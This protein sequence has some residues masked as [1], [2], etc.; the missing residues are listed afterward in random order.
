MVLELS[1][2]HQGLTTAEFSARISAATQEPLAV[3]G[4]GGSG[5]VH[6]AVESCRRLRRQVLYVVADVDTALSAAADAGFYGERLAPDEPATSRNAA[7]RNTTPRTAKRQSAPVDAVEPGTVE[8]GTV[9]PG[10][11]EPGTVEPGTRGKRTPSSASSLASPVLV[12]PSEDPPWAQVHPDRRATMR[13]LA[14]LGRLVEEPTPRVVIVSAGALKRRVPSPADLRRQCLTLRVGDTVRLDELVQRLSLAGYLRVPLAEDPGTM[15]LRGGLLDLWS[16]A[17]ESPCRI[18]LNGEVVERL[19]SFDPENQRTQEDFDAY[20]V[21]PCVEGALDAE[22]RKQ[23]TRRVSALADAIDYP[24]NQTKRLVESL[25]AGQ[26]FF[27]SASYAVALGDWGSLLDYFPADVPVLVED[28]AKV[29]AALREEDDELRKSV[30]SV[31]DRPHFPFEAW[32]FDDEALDDRL[33]LH[34]RVSLLRIAQ[35]GG[36]DGT[37]LAWLETSPSDVATLHARDHAELGQQL[38]S[39]R[40]QAGAASALEPLTLALREWQETGFDVTV[41]ARARTQLDRLAQILGHRGVSIALEEPRRAEKG[42]GAM[43]ANA[44]RLCTGTLSRGVV[45]PIELRV[46]LT[47]EEIFGQRSHRHKKRERSAEGSLEDL[48]SLSPGDYVVHT[49]H[50]IGRYLGLERRELGGTAV[51]LIS[52][53][54][55]AGK[56]Y[57]PIYR[58]NQI[59]KYSGSEAAPKLDRLGGLS[60]A[61]TK[62]RVQRKVRQMADELLKLY[63]ERLVAERPPLAARDDDYSSFEA[64]FPFE[65]TRDQ[66]AAILDVLE[67]LESNK[68]MDRLVCGDVGFGKTEVALRAAYRVAASGRQ[69][70]LLCPTTVLAQQHER[71]FRARLADFG[72]EVRGLSRFTRPNDA[73]EA[74]LGLKR[75]TVDVIVGTHRLLSKDVDFKQLGLLIVDEEQRFGV[76]HKERIKQLRGSVDVL[77]LSATPIPRT[78]QMAV[79]GLRDLSMISTPPL[80][81]RSI[82]TIIAKTEDTVL[83]DAIS[84]E[85]ERG[86]QVFY[87]YNR[88]A[89]LEERAARVAQLFPSATI[90]IAHGQMGED[91]LERAMMRFVNGDA[92]ILVSTAIIENGI[93]IPRANTL[94]VDRA[95]LFGLSQLYQLRGRVGRSKERAYCYLLV[96][97]LSELTGEARSRLEAIERFSELGSGLKVAALDLE[98]R[99]A[100]DFLGAEQ[101][102][103]VSS[104]GFELFCHLLRDAADEARGVP[105]RNDVEPELNFDIEALLPEDYVEDVGIRLSLYKRFSSASDTAEVDELAWS[106]EDRFG[107]A[108]TEAR[109]LVQLM[110][111]KTILRKLSVLSCEANAESVRLRLREDTPLDPARIGALVADASSGYRLFPDGSLLAKRRA[112]ERLDSGLDLLGRVFDELLPLLGQSEQ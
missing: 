89:G 70:A 94:L 53:E 101:S 63:S 110:R 72:L 87:V 85:L 61:K 45:L 83:V 108:P 37:A 3:T 78:L 90:A 30:A 106:M 60:F 112:G 98:L 107:P 4:L 51:E 11:V 6:Y 95:D 86:G 111:H 36:T 67:D 33:R 62:A 34:P 64:T 99:G 47:E 24:S 69:V 54:Y 91:Q 57:L 1:P 2:N 35:L 88:V 71:S 18:E 13:R 84:R 55:L 81:R 73:K 46:Y 109:H 76:T 48:Q 43:N 75:G 9:E 56:L 12:L 40:K 58:L 41:V 103:F 21:T 23:V 8:P 50:G 59:A 29:R 97:S 96:P 32:A 14:A 26:A 17:E 39:A 19:R 65:E 15:A 31:A 28:G 5:G 102:G 68:V 22:G 27:G 38:A 25:L 16:P 66:S 80:D 105:V 7:R 20:F 79:G 74:L 44:I 10:T 104:V 52:I 100:G 42:V 82:R 77:T 49:E 93:D 92:Q